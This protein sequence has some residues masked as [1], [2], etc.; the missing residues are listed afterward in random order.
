[1]Y[2]VDLLKALLR[3][4]GDNITVTKQGFFNTTADAVL[5]CEAAIKMT[6]KK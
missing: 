1:M 2:K 5:K 4:L 6:A 3:I